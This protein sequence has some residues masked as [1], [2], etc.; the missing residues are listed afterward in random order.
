[1]ELPFKNRFK[2]PTQA[3]RVL[4]FKPV[5]ASGMA[6]IFQSILNQPAQNPERLLYI[7]I[8][9]CSKTCSF[10]IYN[11]YA[12]TPGHI[13][14]SYVDTLI[15]QIRSAA[16]A[17]WVQS[18]PFKAVYFGG[19]T[20]T[21]IPSKDLVRIV[22]TINQHIPLA[23]GCEITVESTISNITSSLV[24]SLAKAG[25]NRISLGVQTFDNRIRE[26][27]G[28]ESN[29]ETIAK[30]IRTIRESGISNICIDL[31]YGLPN[32]T[33][34]SWNADLEMVTQL[35]I[36]GCS[37]YPLVSKPNG[38][39]NPTEFD[40]DLEYKLFSAAHNALNRIDGW[41]QY[42]PVQYGH[43]TNGQA[44]YVSG[45]GQNADLLALGA[46]AGGRI[47]THTYFTNPNVEEF[48]GCKANF[49]QTPKI[50]MSIDKE[51][52]NHSKVFTL[53]EGLCLN[54]QNRQELKEVFDNNFDYLK[55]KGLILESNES[56]QL[57]PTGC[58]W[59]ANISDV[60]AQR[61]GKVLQG[62]TPN[63]Y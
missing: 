16:K 61:I 39:G 21:A 58:F 5:P 38:E 19:G 7:H 47:N 50:M 24:E 53:S 49:A 46:G 25:V 31:I 32:Q 40:I 13:M 42:T 55:E 6:E 48:M 44:I 10:C 9:F 43:S 34:E 59:A 54:K 45:H 62:D 28:R 57:T 30:K 11:R 51:F 27:L 4:P 18:A 15:S 8:P 26:S 33:I 14:T 36:T 56:L 17:P 63:H 3:R 41:Q 1:M 2:S 22:N 12:N 23:S 52:L 35:P 20:P 29:S 60:F 37:V